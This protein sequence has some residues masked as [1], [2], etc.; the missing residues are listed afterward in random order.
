AALYASIQQRLE[1]IPGVERATYSLYSPMEGN[2]WSSGI[3]ISGRPFDPEHRDSSSWNRVG[4]A[5]F[6]TLGTRLVRGRGITAADTPAA[7]HVA[8]VNQAFAQK[9]L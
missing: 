1:Q 8:V 2:N 6:E 3:A 5:Y 7:E 4:P 9:F